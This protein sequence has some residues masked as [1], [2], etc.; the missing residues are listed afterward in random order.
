MSLTCVHSPI[1]TSPSQ[2]W[3]HHSK[4]HQDFQEYYSE[5]LNDRGVVTS[6]TS[7][8]HIRLYG[9]SLVEITRRASGVKVDATYRLEGA[10]MSLVIHS[11]GLLLLLCTRKFES[12]IFL[13]RRRGIFTRVIC[14]MIP[15]SHSYI[16]LFPFATICSTARSSI[17]YKI[18]LL[19]LLLAMYACI[20][21]PNILFAPAI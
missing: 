13:G 2:W 20:Y 3:I 16:G 10:R 14:K 8:R 1:T 7:P 19:C 15:P 18:P 5:I 17:F 9:S 11:L 12:V 6:F 21:I 4:I